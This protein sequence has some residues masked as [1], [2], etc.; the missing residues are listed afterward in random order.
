[1]P[2]FNDRQHLIKLHQALRIFFP[3]GSSE[4][5]CDCVRAVILRLFWVQTDLSTL[6]S[7]PITQQ[8]E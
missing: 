3:G 1:M 7:N 6:C 8:E 2:I 4:C 5:L